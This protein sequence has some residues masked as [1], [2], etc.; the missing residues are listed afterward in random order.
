MPNIVHCQHD[1]VSHWG[2]CRRNKISWKIKKYLLGRPFLV[3]G[4]INPILFSG[5]NFSLM[6]CNWLTIH[7]SFFS[8]SSAIVHI[9][10]IHLLTHS[11]RNLLFAF[12]PSVH[13][14]ES[15]VHCISSRNPL[16]IADVVVVSFTSFIQLFNDLYSIYFFVVRALICTVVDVV[17]VAGSSSSSMLFVIYFEYFFFA[18]VFFVIF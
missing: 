9:F 16:R 12:P 1:L 10:F 4:E 18:A 15:R 8:Y 17:A 5:S 2:F 14:T 13:K 11:A 7:S 3:E 6:F